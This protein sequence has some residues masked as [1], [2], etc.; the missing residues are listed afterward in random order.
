MVTF[1]QCYR[2]VYGEGFFNHD[3][4]QL[5]LSGALS[6]GERLPRFVEAGHWWARNLSSILDPA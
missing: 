6:L 5:V 3:Q 4:A 1:D 2:F